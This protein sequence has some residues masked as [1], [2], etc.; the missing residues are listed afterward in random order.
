MIKVFLKKVF[1]ITDFCIKV[2]LK[3][4]GNYLKNGLALAYEACNDK[5]DLDKFI[6]LKLKAA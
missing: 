5:F 1:E 6:E 4:R 3:R 2:E